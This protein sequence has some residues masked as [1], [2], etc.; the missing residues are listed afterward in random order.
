[1]IGKTDEI[2]ADNWDD[3][4]DNHEFNDDNEVQVQEVQV[5]EV[6]DL[7]VQ[8]ELKDPGKLIELV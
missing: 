1:M 8:E 3:F 2:E 6:Q 4:D 7:L 5:H